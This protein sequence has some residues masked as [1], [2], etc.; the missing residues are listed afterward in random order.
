MKIII[1]GS[2]GDLAKRKLFLA[3]SKI[4]LEGVEI[5]GY[6]RTKYDVEFSEVLQEEGS[7][8]PDF[9]AKI[10][11]V[12]GPYDNLSGLKE[13][14]GPDTVFY[15]SV[16]PSVYTTLLREISKLGYGIAGIEKPY[17]SKRA[18]FEEMKTFNLDRVVFIDHYLLKPLVVAMPELIAESAKIQDLLSNRHVASVQIMSKEAIGGEGRH[19]FD[20]NGIIKDIVQ[21]HMAE[22]LGV[23]AA[24]V[25]RPCK[26]AEC[27]ARTRVFRDC[28]VDTEHCVY[29]QYESYSK[30]LHKES[31]TETFCVVPIHINSQRW[32]KV[33]FII[34]AGKGMNEKK[35]EIVFEFRKESFAKCIDLVSSKEEFAYRAMAMDDISEVRLVFDVYPRR[36]VFLE[37]RIAGDTFEYSLFDRRTIDEIMQAHYGAYQ[38]HEIIFDGLIR[39]AGFSSVS[40]GEAELLWKIFDPIL[41]GEKEKRLFYYSKG[42]DLPAEAENMIRVIKNR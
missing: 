17:G 36:E 33:P 31:S 20:D 10:T 23:A 42:I 38:D 40:S 7:Y 22:L 26:S 3:L 1:F 19:Y 14:I 2:S 32:Q 27:D 39:K 29:G 34:I 6:A 37:V 13:M 41:A 21:N 4:N 15:F 28:V 35:T 30:E 8:S 24:D 16:P 5:I 11:Y 25:A 12:R 18:S 9:L